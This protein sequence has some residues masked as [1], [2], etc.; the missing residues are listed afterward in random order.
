LAALAATPT[1]SLSTRSLGTGGSRVTPCAPAEIVESEFFSSE[2]F[3]SRDKD[4]YG[5]PTGSSI[6]G[7]AVD[8]NI[9]EFAVGFAA[10]VHKT[11]ERAT[12]K[13]VAHN[14][15]MLEGIVKVLA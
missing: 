14:L 15:G 11:H 6:G 7:G 9:V 8:S 1:T 4:S 12:L 2:D 10:M 13:G 3:A 5:F